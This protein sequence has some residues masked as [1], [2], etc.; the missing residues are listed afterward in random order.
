MASSTTSS[1]ATTRIVD[2]RQA[3]G[4][5]APLDLLAVAVAE[6]GGASAVHCCGPPS[7]GLPRS[8]GHL[9][10]VIAAIPQICISRS[11]HVRLSTTGVANSFRGPVIPSRR[12]RPPSNFGRPRD[13]LGSRSAQQ[14]CRFNS[15]CP[16]IGPAGPRGTRQREARRR[17]LFHLRT[18]Y[19]PAGLSLQKFVRHR[20]T[21]PGRRLPESVIPNTVGSSSHVGSGGPTKIWETCAQAHKPEAHLH[22]ANN[23]T[24]FCGRSHGRKKGPGRCEPSRQALLLEEGVLRLDRQVREEVLAGAVVPRRD[25]RR[26]CELAELETQ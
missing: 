3:C 16:D 1:N 7:D 18:R 8:G 19:R 4:D 14:A 22:R 10:D 23:R 20:R 6:A 11:V 2:D 17:A 15:R 26:A 24:R 5:A 21:W 9:Q 12:M 13:A 25:R